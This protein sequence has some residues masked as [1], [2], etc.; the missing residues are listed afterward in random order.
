MCLSASQLCKRPL[1]CQITVFK[2]RVN[3]LSQEVPWVI[4]LH[5]CL[6]MIRK[7]LS[8]SSGIIRAH[9]GLLWDHDTWSEQCFNCPALGDAV[10]IEVP[11]QEPWQVKAELSEEMFC[12][13]PIFQG[14]VRSNSDQKTF[15]GVYVSSTCVCVST[16]SFYK[17]KI[18]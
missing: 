12:H 10:S 3:I 6:K 18:L 17:S 16:S 7:N 1:T 15:V 5:L 11:W 14:S 13:I 8:F 4:L 9:N 2:G